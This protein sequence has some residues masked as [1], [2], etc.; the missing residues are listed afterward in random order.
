MATNLGTDQPTFAE[1]ATGIVDDAQRLMRQEVTL[2]RREM[3]DA[4]DKAREAAISLVIGAVLALL[5]GTLLGFAIVYALHEYA[6][7]SRAAGFALV[8][9]V[10]AVIGGALA[11]FAAQ[12]AKEVS[13]LPRQAIE[14]ITETNTNGGR[15]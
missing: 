13:L 5:G 8:G 4:W 7:W 14:T 10:F 9:A 11:Y 15:S 3:Q 2:V 6:Q 1:L 12:K